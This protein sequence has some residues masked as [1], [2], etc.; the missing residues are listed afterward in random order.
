MSFQQDLINKA[1]NSGQR[2]DYS[3]RQL[4]SA[5][6]T[7]KQAFERLMHEA[8]HPTTGGPGSEAYSDLMALYQAGYDQDSFPDAN[9]AGVPRSVEETL[10]RAEYAVQDKEFT[11]IH[12]LL[13]QVKTADGVPI[14]ALGVEGSYQY[15]MEQMAVA[16]PQGRQQLGELVSAWHESGSRVFDGIK[17]EAPDSPQ[18]SL[19]WEFSSENDNDRDQSGY[20]QW[21]ENQLQEKTGLAA[22]QMSN[23]Q[24]ADQLMFGIHQSH[25]GGLTYDAQLDA[26]QTSAYGGGGDG[27]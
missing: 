8:Y 16:G 7:S 2:L 4:R 12:P 13:Q 18:D 1:N 17:I 22:L 15:I 21:R 6:P 24:Q 5:M 27:E 25:D 9:N 19:T 26:A 11:N 20:T 23:A 14:A 10:H 3:Q